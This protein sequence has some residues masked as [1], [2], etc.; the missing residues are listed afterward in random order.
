M[1]SQSFWVNPNWLNENLRCHFCG[2]TQSVK[3]KTKVIIIDTIPNS[4]DVEKEVCICN[5]CVLLTDKIM[6]VLNACN[7]KGIE[8]SEN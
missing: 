3:Y 1:S 4:E 8:I 7:K 5:K 6:K 2:N